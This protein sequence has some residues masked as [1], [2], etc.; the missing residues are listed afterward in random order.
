MDVAGSQEDGWISLTIQYLAD[1]CIR[2]GNTLQE[3]CSADP[4]CCRSAALKPDE[5]ATLE[6]RPQ[7]LKI[8]GL[9]YKMFVVSITML[10]VIS[11]HCSYD[12]RRQF[13]N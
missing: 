9:R 6:L 10:D 11:R 13:A 2:L 3:H 5:P 12:C 1:E 8:Q 7:T 4:C